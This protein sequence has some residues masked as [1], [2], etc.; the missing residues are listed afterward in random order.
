MTAGMAALLREPGGEVFVH[1]VWVGG[2][3]DETL[4][5]YPEGDGLFEQEGLQPRDKLR[6][7]GRLRGEGSLKARHET[8]IVP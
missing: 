5:D 1:S 7:V 2:R 8:D 4:F 6:E 3:G